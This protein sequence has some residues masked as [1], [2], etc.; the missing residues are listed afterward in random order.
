VPPPAVGARIGVFKLSKRIDQDIS[1]VC[2][3]CSVSVEAGQI[4]AARVALGGMAAVAARSPSAEKALVGAPWSRATFEA[5]AAALAQDFK[6]LSDMRASSD[7]RMSGA[8]N[9][10][11]RFFLSS[12]PKTLTRV[13]DVTV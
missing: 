6:P 1:A 9:L 3:A 13:A 2:L 4:T 7:Y 10:L 5:A 8:A 11:R 12:E